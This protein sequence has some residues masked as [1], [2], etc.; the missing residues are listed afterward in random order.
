MIFYF[1]DVI[2]FYAF[3][4]NC[5][6]ESDKLALFTSY[7]GAQ[8]A[9]TS[10]FGDPAANTPIQKLQT[11]QRREYILFRCLELLYLLTKHFDITL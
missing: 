10:N 2:T 3:R 9:F 11:V 1:L 5:I 7:E 8:A 4:F 6:Q